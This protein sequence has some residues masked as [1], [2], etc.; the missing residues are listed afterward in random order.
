[1]QEYAA[2]KGSRDDDEYKTLREETKRKAGAEGFDRMFYEYNVVAV[3]MPTRGPADVMKPNGTATPD[4][5]PTEKRD[6]AQSASSIAALAGYPNLNVPM[7]ML[8]GMPLG[9]SL[10]GPAWSEAELL[11][12]GYAYEQ[13]S[14]LRVPP[15]AY[16]TAQGN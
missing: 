3:V 16:K 11:N 15:T 10:V 2:S 6:H 9:L 8:D 7:G 13:A 4:R 14:H 1:M 5:I 12:L